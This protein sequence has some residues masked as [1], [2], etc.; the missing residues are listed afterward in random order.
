MARPLP[1]DILLAGTGGALLVSGLSG[2]SLAEVIKGDFGKIKSNPAVSPGKES[3][4]NEAKGLEESAAEL[5]K[6]VP[7]SNPNEGTDNRR[8]V[9]YEGGG[10]NQEPPDQAILRQTYM[11]PTEEAQLR[12]RIRIP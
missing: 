1:V 8:N 3:G 7:A 4:S 9:S 12:R 11:T 5:M 10:P 6:L 2:V